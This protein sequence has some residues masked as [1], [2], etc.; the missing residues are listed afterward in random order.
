VPKSN[1][2][3][4]DTAR[5]YAKNGI[6]VFPLY[7]SRKADG[8]K[9]VRPL[10]LWRS[11]SSTS[12]ADIG[13]WELQYPD[14][15]LGIDCGKS[16][17]VVIDP[18]GNEGVRNWL[19]LEP[20]AP[21]GVVT[22]PGGGE[23]WYY[24]EDSRH[25]I[26][27]DQDGK[28]APKVDVRGLGGFVI[29]PPSSDGTGPWEWTV[30]PVW[31]F[32]GGVVPEVVIE[33][34]KAQVKPKV[35]SGTGATDRPQETDDLFDDATDER[36]FTDE[37][38]TAFIRNA[39]GKLKGAESGLNG[40]IN[41]FAM[42]CAHFPWLVDR[43]KCAALVQRHLG[44]RMGWAASDRDDRKT[45]DS[46]YS[47]TEAGRRSWTAVRIEPLEQNNLDED[48]PE[49]RWTDA[50]LSGRLAREEL[51]QVAVYTS[52]LGW[53]QWDRMRWAAVSDEVMHEICRRW[54]LRMYA[55]AVTAYRAIPAPDHKLSEDPAVKG[56][57][58]A[59]S[60]NRIASIVKL[61][62]GQVLRD[63]GDFDRDPDLLNCPNGVIDLRTGEVLKHDPDRLITKLAGTDYVPGAFSPALKAALEAV[64][65]DSRDWLQRRLGEAATG[66]SGEELVLLSGT[67]R[68][69]KTLLMGAA[70]RALGSYA[71]KVPN[72]LLL[73]ARQ[74]GGA[75]PER[76]TLRGVRLAYMEETPED[77]YLDATV[78]K[79]LLDAEEIEGRHLY[80]DIVSWRPTH[81]LFLNTNHPPTMGDTSDAAW[82]RLTRLDFPYRFRRVSEEIESERDRRGDPGLKAAL[83]HTHEGQRALLAWIVA[84][85]RAYYASGIE[86]EVT[87]PAVVAG[88]TT[89]REE[90]DDLLR[91]IAAE[92]T[93]APDGWVAKS[94]M[95]EAFSVWLRQGGQK[96]LS[97][98]TFG[99]RMDAHS[100]LSR[101]VQVGRIDKSKVTRPAS[102]L[103]DGLMRPLP[104]RVHS[105]GGLIFATPQTSDLQE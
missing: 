90:S 16:G 68:N 69:G 71:A 50:M 10:G 97:V 22:T 94:D 40:A 58:G 32:T 61:A 91:F 20:S 26:G 102:Y 59:Q 25:P 62:R 80:K 13:A 33:R 17:L 47:A 78:V 31:D 96:S 44:E 42:S 72:T 57:A 65:A 77:G 28:V 14:A 1:S 38:A 4:W 27:N 83:G 6:Y 34:M 11:I 86:D 15:G 29:A 63:A 51:A 45:I 105:Y 54:V 46:A 64:P 18:D 41:A 103:T 7:V 95:Y 66:H 87:P 3:V 70:F 39:A 49:D 30:G 81:S 85:A 100:I 24:R 88:V 92:M 35:I 99:A 73:R 21:L 36:R 74:S 52:A 89:W 12:L 76:M 48:E 23:H 79:D 67:G 75:T 93:W 101:R 43:E 55:G 84:G 37:Q 5:E 53:L 2:I 98:K 82:R 60:A 8:R 104:D 9:D 19:D 56:W